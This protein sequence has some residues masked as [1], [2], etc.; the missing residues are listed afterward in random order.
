M[1][2]VFWK[3]KERLFAG[4]ASFGSLE[5]PVRQGVAL[6]QAAVTGRLITGI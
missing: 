3:V 2:L 6:V 5:C 1:I 4:F